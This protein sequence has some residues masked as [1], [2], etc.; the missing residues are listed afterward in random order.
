MDFVVA[1]EAGEQGD[2]GVDH[3][4][5]LGDHDRAAPEA[6]QPVPLAG[7]VALDPMRLVLTGVKPTRRDQ[8]GVGRPLV[9]AIEA[10][11]PALEALDQLG[12]GGLVTTTQ[13]PIDEPS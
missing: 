8:L 10:R 12:A 6:G 9:R 5:G 11:A 3:A 1:A 4:F 2:R 13:F 7:M